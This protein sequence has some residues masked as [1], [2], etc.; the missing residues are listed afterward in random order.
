MRY[1]H[2]EDYLRIAKEKPR[3]H[4]SN[5]DEAGLEIF[6]LSVWPGVRHEQLSIGVIAVFGIPT[7]L[8][9]TTQLRTCHARWSNSDAYFWV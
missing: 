3:G 2:H 6:L 7:V 9:S 1:K 5:P 4:I 8:P